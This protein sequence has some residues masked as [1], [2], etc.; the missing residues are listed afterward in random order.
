V[1]VLRSAYRHGVATEDTLHAVRNAIVI[2][3]IAEDPTRYLVG[4]YSNWSCW[5]GP[6]GRP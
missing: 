2:E 4:T 6:K 1:E 3:E 5:I